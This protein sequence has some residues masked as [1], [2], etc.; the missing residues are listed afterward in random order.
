MS[1]ISSELGREMGLTIF[2]GSD[3]KSSRGMDC[4]KART[5]KPTSKKPWMS[6]KWAVVVGWLDAEE[7]PSAPM[8]DGTAARPK[9]PAKLR[10]IPFPKFTPSF[11]KEEDHGL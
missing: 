5:S 10:K 1:A 2:D 3:A 9:N 4:W 7:E 11:S 6:E 8:Y